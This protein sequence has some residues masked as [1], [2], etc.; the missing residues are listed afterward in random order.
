MKVH[1]GIV[2][3]RKRNREC[4]ICNARYSSKSNL[5]K[6]IDRVHEGKEGHQCSLC[7]ASYTDKRNL[8]DH[9]Q[10]AHEGKKFE[11]TLCDKGK[12]NQRKI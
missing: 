5:K 8:D 2:H 1:I 9:I 11:C 7:D 10:V 12:Y 3:E 6:H 4:S